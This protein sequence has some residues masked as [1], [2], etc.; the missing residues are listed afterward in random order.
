M[1]IAYLVSVLV[2]VGFGFY[3]L[4]GPPMEDRPDRLTELMHQHDFFVRRPKTRW[5][6]LLLNMFSSYAWARRLL[7]GVWVSYIHD[8][9]TWHAIITWHW[10]EKRS[11]KE[12]SLPIFRVEEYN[13]FKQQDS[14]IKNE[15]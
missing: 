15:N 14:L 8:I 7:G 12:S 5:Q 4:L 3:V 11:Y 13:R 10:L 9:G 6:R 1:W 2:P